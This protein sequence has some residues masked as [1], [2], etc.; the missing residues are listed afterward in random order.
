[1]QSAHVNPW[2]DNPM[3]YSAGDLK[4]RFQWTY[5]IVLSPH[6]PNTLYAAAQVLFRT[7]DDGMSWKAISPDLTRHDP[8]TLGPSGGPIT[9]DQTSV[10]YYATDLRRRRVAAHEG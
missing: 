4:Y 6:D 2:P 1:M 10:E 8:R 9:K 3:G 7:R 5:P